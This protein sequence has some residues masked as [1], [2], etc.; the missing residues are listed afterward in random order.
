MA[1][2]IRII[3]NNPKCGIDTVPSDT[4]VNSTL[5]IAWLI[6]NR[7]KNS[8]EKI[9]FNSAIGRNRKTTIGKVFKLS[10]NIII[11][12]IDST[13]WG[14]RL[15]RKHSEEYPTR[16]MLWFPILN[17]TSSKT[18]YRILFFLYHYVPAFFYDIVLKIQGSKISVINIYSKIWT[19]GEL[20][21]YFMC[22]HWDFADDN[23]RYL[24]DQI[25]TEKDHHEFPVRF[26]NDDYE[27]LALDLTKGLRKYFFKDNDKDLE[28]ARKKLKIFKILHYLLLFT[29]YG[30]LILCVDYVLNLLIAYFK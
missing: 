23:M 4:V 5:A 14:S 8:D 29:T 7:N 25:M 18:L 10:K 12:F 1:G 28:I 27:Q 17:E 22:R 19:T 6:S 13:G 15:V 3:K 11:I 9:V 30:F 16:K 21:D 2:L 26:L 24:Y 20:L